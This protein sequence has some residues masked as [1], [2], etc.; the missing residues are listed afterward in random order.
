MRNKLSWLGNGEV[1][2]YIHPRGRLK[3]TD[4]GLPFLG[5]TTAQEEDGFTTEYLDSADVPPAINTSPRP[6][7]NGVATKLEEVHVNG[8]GLNG[9][10]PDV[11]VKE[12]VEAQM[13]I[14]S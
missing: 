14:P 10:V 13:T 2:H 4:F 7:V 3:Y 9:K 5:L 11:V 1:L 6:D 8:N 12:L